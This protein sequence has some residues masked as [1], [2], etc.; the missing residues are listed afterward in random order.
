MGA[1]LFHGVLSEFVREDEAKDERAQRKA[2]NVYVAAVNL[3]QAESYENAGADGGE[4]VEHGVLSE[5]VEVVGFEEGDFLWRGAAE[6]HHVFAD[7]GL[8]LG[9]VG[10]SW[11]ELEG[12]DEF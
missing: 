9:A 12:G 10:V 6:R 5:V 4:D 7:V 1:V 8:Q 3:G 11:V 2:G